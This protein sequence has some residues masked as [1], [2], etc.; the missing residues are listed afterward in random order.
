[1]GA[2]SLHGELFRMA[3]S[4]LCSAWCV[5]ADIDTDALFSASEDAI[6]SV[7]DSDHVTRISQDVAPDLTSFGRTNEHAVLSSTSD[8][9]DDDAAVG[10]VP[11]TVADPSNRGLTLEIVGLLAVGKEFAAEDKSR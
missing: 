6:A 10:S 5:V 1:M 11:S 9:H 4:E 7:I 8:A 2:A 3:S